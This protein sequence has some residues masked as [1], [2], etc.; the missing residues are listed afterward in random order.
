M[1]K[2]SAKRRLR[3]KRVAKKR[4]EDKPKRK[5]KALFKELEYKKWV[6]RVENRAYEAEQK[7]KYVLPR[8]K[9]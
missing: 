7:K 2:E 8:V 9:F 1:K 4:Q 5:T 6:V 3:N